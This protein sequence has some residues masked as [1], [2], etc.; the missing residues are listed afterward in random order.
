[1]K[2]IVLANAVELELPAAIKIHPEVNVSRIV[3]YKEQVEG[4]RLVPPAPVEIGE[5]QEYEVEKIL[6]KKLFR[7]KTRYLVRWKGYTAEEDTWEKEEDLENAKEAVTEFEEQYGE[8]RRMTSREEEF[9]EGFDREMLGKFMAKVLF[10]WD[11]KKFDEEYL[12]KLERSWKRWRG[13]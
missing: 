13:T 5:E 2:K 12:L 4:Q 3:M 11:D 7:G 10:R 1:M 8:N 6:N 9:E